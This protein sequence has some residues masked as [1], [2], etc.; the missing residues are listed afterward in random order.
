MKPIRLVVFSILVLNAPPFSAADQPNLLLFMAD[1]MTWTDIG[2]FG[3][4]QIRTP[5]LDE[6][7]RQGMKLNGM[8]TP[9]P[10]CS[11]LRQALYT[12]IYPVRNGAHPNHARVYDGVK[13]LAHHLRPLGYRVGLVG[14]RHEAP[15][16]AFPFDFLG[17]SHGD[18]GKPGTIDLDLNLADEFI[19]RDPDQPY[20]LVVT[21]NQPHTPWNRGDAS[22]YDAAALTLPPY[23]VDTPVTREWMTHYYAEITY[24]DAQVGR[25]MELVSQT[26]QPTLFLFL[27][28][29]GSNFPHCKWTCYDTGIRGASIVWWP[30]VVRPGSESDALMQYVDVVPTF[31]EVAGG[32]PEDETKYDF[33][34]RSFL[35][36][37]EGEMNRFREY[38]FAVQTSRGIYSGPEAY[39][40]RAVRDAR[41]KYIWNL[42]APAAFSN[43]VIT[44]FPPFQDWKRAAAAG[45]PAAAR[46]VDEYIHRPAEEF[47]DLRDDPYELNNLAGDPQHRARMDSMKV[48]LEAWMKQQGDRGVATE[49][50]AKKRQVDG[51]LYWNKKKNEQKGA[52]LE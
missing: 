27:S 13:S 23:L 1:D 19:H 48:Q 26:N 38:V 3:N 8:F 9:A 7:A 46:L 35:A 37:L 21:S 33:D 41:Y 18:G 6:L 16:E 17:G 20:C 49:M 2:A 11:P 52:S 42:N 30:G 29:Q 47:Y 4:D 14:K 44:K 32:I 22:V 28:E 43:T 45:D 10:T 25:C 12:G 50:A 51:K 15:S 34:G 31:V 36:V 39:G 40:I 5:H 24:M